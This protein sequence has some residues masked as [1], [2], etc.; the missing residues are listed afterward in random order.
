[1]VGVEFEYIISGMEDDVECECDGVRVSLDE[2]K[3]L[4]E[5]Y[6]LSWYAVI[7]TALDTFNGSGSSLKFGWDVSVEIR[8]AGSVALVGR[9]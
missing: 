2:V 6:G 4:L 5:Y 1:M 9:S 7:G 8:E 3:E